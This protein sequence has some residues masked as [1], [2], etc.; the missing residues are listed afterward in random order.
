MCVCVC[1]A[2]WQL[3]RLATRRMTNSRGE[4]GAREGW[5]VGMRGKLHYPGFERRSKE[6]NYAIRDSNIELRKETAL[7]GIRT[8]LPRGQSPVRLTER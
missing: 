1:V 6:R 8:L 3:S 4:T 5:G 2:F 7:S